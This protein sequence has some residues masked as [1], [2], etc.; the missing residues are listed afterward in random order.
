[1]VNKLSREFAEITEQERKIMFAD[2]QFSLVL[3]TDYINVKENGKNV[4]ILACAAPNEKAMFLLQRKLV[5]VPLLR[6][7][8][9]LQ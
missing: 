4:S 1:M 6:A 5:K 2:L 3:H 8:D 7:F 9:D